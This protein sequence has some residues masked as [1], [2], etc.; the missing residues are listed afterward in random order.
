MSTVISINPDT[1]CS[2]TWL[3][4][5]SHMGSTG[6]VLVCQEM[7]FFT[8][9]PTDDIQRLRRAG[10]SDSVKWGRSDLKLGKFQFSDF[11]ECTDCA[12]IKDLGLRLSERVFVYNN[13]LGPGTGYTPQQLVYGIS[14]GIPGIFQISKNPDALFAQSLQRL[15]AGI[16][17]AQE[18]GVPIPLGDDFPYEPGDLV[19]FLGPHGRI[20][21]G[22]ILIKSGKDYRVAHSGTRISLLS[23]E[24]ISPTLRT[25]KSF[26]LRA[27]LCPK[28]NNKH[29]KM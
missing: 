27:A 11:L 16:H 23:K 10:R 24:Y 22:Y 3:W 5:I 9:D 17:Y 29:N 14:S 19:H 7:L 28:L 13:L 18:R 25:R 12:E 1:R 26:S 6:T 2:T 15:I 8:A 20:G 21:Q 4:N